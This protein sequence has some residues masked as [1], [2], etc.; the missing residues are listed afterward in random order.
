M[1]KDTTPAQ[2]DRRTALAREIRRR[3]KRANTLAEQA[4]TTEEQLY[5]DGQAAAF[6]EC[7]VLLEE[8]G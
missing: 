8:L 1:N 4:P 5:H 7:A 3:A 6:E 2:A